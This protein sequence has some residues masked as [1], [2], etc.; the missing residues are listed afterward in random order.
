MAK[1]KMSRRARPEDPPQPV[2]KPLTAHVPVPES[3]SPTADDVVE[4]RSP[5]PGPPVAGIGASAGGLDAFKKFFSAMPENS[6]IAFVLIPHLDP[7]HESLMVDLIARHTSMP[8]VEATDGLAVLENRVYIIPPNKYMTFSGGSLRLTGPVERGGPPTS[9]DLFLRSL[10]EEKQE[11]AI[12]IILSGTGSHGTL[13]LKAVKAAGGMA[14]VQDPATADYPLMPESAV[15]TGLADYVLAAEQLPDALIKYTQPFCVNGRHQ[16]SAEVE[17]PDYLDQALAVLRTRGKLDFRSYR[18]KTLA[19]RIVRRMSLSHLERGADYVAFLRDHADEVDRLASD[20]LISVTSF[21]RD[22]DAWR[23]METQVFRPLVKSHEADAPLRV[24]SVGCATGEEAY[25]LGILAL[26]QLAATQKSCP[27][28]IFATDVDEKALETARHGVYPDSICTDVSAQRL[29]QFFTRVSESSFQVSK[30]LRETA[31]FAR[32][33]VLA[34]AP[35]SKL[36]LIVCRNLLIYLEPEAQKRIIGLL[37]FALRPGGYLFLGPAETIGRNANLF[38]Q[39]SAKWRIYQSIGAPRANLQ[40]PVPQVIPRPA[41]AQ[42]APRAERPVRLGEVAQS[43]L[44]R[45]F[46][47]ACVVI[48]RN[49]QVLHFGGPTENFLVQP[50]GPPTQDLLSL[51]RRGLETKLRGLIHRAMREGTAQSIKDVVMRHEG[52]SRRVTIDVEPLDQSK[53]TEGLLLVAFQEQPGPEHET[54]AEAKKRSQ[55]EQSSALRELEQELETTRESLQCTIEELESSNE[56]LK[57]S[58]E[59]IMSMN[60]E[61]QST[62]EELESSKEELQSVNEELNTLNVQ[63]AEKLAELEKANNDTANL[64]NCTDIATVFLDA[65]FKIRFF[66]PSAT[67]MFSFIATDVGRPIAH[68]APKFTDP[69]L[70]RDADAVLHDLAPRER[71]VEISDGLWYIRRIVPY[72]TLDNRIDG[73]V[74]NFVDVT[75]RKRTADAVVRRLAAIVES[76]A[77]AIFSKDLDGTVRTWNA[78]AERLHSRRNRGPVDPCDRPG[79]P[80]PRM[81]ER[82]VAPGARRASRANG[83]RTNLQ[84]RRARSR[85]ADLLPAP[86]RPRQCRG[87]VRN[88]AKSHRAQSGRAGAAREHRVPARQR[89]PPQRHSQHGRGCHRHDRSRWHHPVRQSGR[90]R[91]VRLRRRGDNRSEREDAHAS[92]LS[93]RARRLPGSIPAN[94]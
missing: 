57:A 27:L 22:A 75:E 13:G 94:G 45:R 65:G 48:N 9:I 33:N 3:P 4:P 76:S 54:L 81:E 28:Q 92:S 5:P 77:D 85:L 11:K 35:F 19:R 15:A 62:N 70:E 26:E 37:H 83:E 50:P 16:Q 63:L 58:N 43:Y 46:G 31:I 67:R 84:E 17:A 49:Y 12:C 21:F 25:S 18:K 1:R 79:R 7:K 66:T 20:L 60:E 10:A 44:L 42:P 59:E 91:D 32:Q 93:G 80:R 2:R 6:G 51:T 8:V 74:I 40:F 23:A 78:G 68:M 47:L 30:Q 89:S 52:A 29:S 53:Q 61:L 14:M 72:K 36:D 87:G 34:D 24:W 64:L 39:I 71:E 82:H 56:E 55:S 88:G 86:R 41:P 90:R 69:D 38:E 73:V